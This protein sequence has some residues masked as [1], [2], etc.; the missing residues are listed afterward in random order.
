MQIWL[1][2]KSPEVL[3]KLKELGVEIVKMPQGEK[4]VFA[5]IASAKLIA[6]AELAGVRYLSPVR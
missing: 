2:D 1:T 4:F 5:R 3:S 6:V